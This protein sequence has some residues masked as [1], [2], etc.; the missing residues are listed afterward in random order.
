MRKLALFLLLLAALPAQAADNIAVTVGTGTTI[1]T[2][3]LAGVHIPKKTLVDQAGAEVGVAAAPWYIRIASGG[4]ASGAI[5]SGAIASGAVASGALAA[6]SMVDFLTVRGTKAAGVAAANSLLT[7][8]VFNTTPPTVA[9]GEQVAT[10]CDAAGRLNAVVTGVLSTVTTVTT[11]TAVTG[12]GVASGAADSGNPLKVGCRYNVTPPTLDDGDRGDCQ[13]DVNGNVKVT[14]VGGTAGAAPGTGSL[15][16]GVGSGATGGLLANVKTC[17]LHAF[18][19]GTDTGSK[20]LVAG[21]ASRKTY[22][23]S[24]I[25]STGTTGA[26]LTLFKGTDADCATSGAAIGPPYALLANDKVGI[27][28]TFWNGFVTATNADYVCV[29]SSGAVQHTAE[30]WYTIQ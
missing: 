21:V 19:T 4:V 18:Y 22:I 24:F 23:C 7:G 25:M 10:Q 2:K 28:S 5:A 1:A 16:Q 3:D 13:M 14:G 12:G 17:D 8:C 15:V 6:G 9:N 30:I 11:V 26:T 27:A 20:T 29:N